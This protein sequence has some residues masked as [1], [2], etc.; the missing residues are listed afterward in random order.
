M[1]TLDTNS[2]VTQSL[3]D[4]LVNSATVNGSF[5]L[6]A[7]ESELSSVVNQVLSQAASGTTQ[8][9]GTA[10]STSG[11]GS[12]SVG[13]GTSS[14]PA[15]SSAGT[16]GSQDPVTTQSQQAA[17]A[18]EPILAMF[19]AGLPSLPTPTVFQSR[20]L[21]VDNTTGAVSLA[22]DPT[23]QS[24][25]QAASPLD[26]SAGGTSTGTASDS[27]SSGTMVHSYDPFWG[28]LA[29]PLVPASGTL[30]TNAATGKSFD[31]GAVVAGLESRYGAGSARMLTQ[32]YNQFGAGPYDTYVAQHPSIDFSKLNFATLPPMTAFQF[33]GPDDSF[34]DA[35]NQN[36]YCYFDQSGVEH[37]SGASTVDRTNA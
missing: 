8:A 26:P 21:L 28:N 27:S 31:S 30:W 12:H 20:D 35:N 18:N 17:A 19:G 10:E 22:T 15:A 4:Q 6:A 13:N 1:V 33:Y 11:T 34:A 23:L 32:L 9:T 25:Q 29:G 3:V 14:D 36:Q 16:G 2:S 5:S 24:S 7:F 37:L